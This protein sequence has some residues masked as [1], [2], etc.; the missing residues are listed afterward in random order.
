MI[1]LHGEPRAIYRVHWT[2]NKVQKDGARFYLVIG[3]IGEGVSPAERHGVALEYIPSKGGFTV[4]DADRKFPATD[5]L[6]GRLL[7][8][9]EVVGTPLAEEVF[10]L[11][12]TI[13]LQDQNIAE[14]VRTAPEAE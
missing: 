12:D 2:P 13:W 6:V 9:K 1:R 8:R 10:A 5:S 3:P 7:S 14:I 11:V 4:L